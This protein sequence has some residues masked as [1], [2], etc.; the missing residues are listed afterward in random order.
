MKKIEILDNTTIDVLLAVS[1]LSK[2]L[3]LTNGITLSVPV[4]LEDANTGERT[5]MESIELIDGKIII[6]HQ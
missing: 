6:K 3:T 2:E 5:A 4:Y 1:D